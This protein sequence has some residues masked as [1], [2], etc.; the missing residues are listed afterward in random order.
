MGNYLR[1]ADVRKIEAL[2][3]LCWSHRRIAREVGCRRETV[4][5]YARLRESKPANLIA[6][7]SELQN[8]PNPITGSELK[9]GGW[10]ETGPG[11]LGSPLS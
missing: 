10:L 5:R 2:L 4:A 8:R 1:M 6:G 11:L 9:K 3:E 7:S